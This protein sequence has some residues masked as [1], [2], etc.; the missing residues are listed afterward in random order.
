M[1]FF[2]FY[3]NKAGVLIFVKL[4]VFIDAFSLGVSAFVLQEIAKLL[5]TRAQ[6]LGQLS[7]VRSPFA[8]EAQAAGYVGYRGGK[9]DDVTVIVSLVKRRF[10]NHVQ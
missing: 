7:S 9:L 4:T 5:A 2:F 8:D 1:F 3:D 6:E 10:S